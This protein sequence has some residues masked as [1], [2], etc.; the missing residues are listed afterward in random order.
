MKESQCK[1]L[2]SHGNKTCVSVNVHWPSP[3]V[4]PRSRYSSCHPDDHMMLYVSVCVI[5]NHRSLHFLFR[6]IRGKSDNLGF[7][8]PACYFS[9]SQ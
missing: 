1:V 4:V 9:E 7:F 6:Q 8:P 5:C 3:V 2:C